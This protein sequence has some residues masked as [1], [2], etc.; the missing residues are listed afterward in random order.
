MVNTTLNE[1]DLSSKH[2]KTL[3]NDKN[4]KHFSTIQI[5]SK[6][7]EVGDT[8]VT[9]MSGA[10]KTNIALKTLNLTRESKR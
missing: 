2:N 4:I 7:N 9:S 8:G 3:I 6:E 5:E 10:L 1:L